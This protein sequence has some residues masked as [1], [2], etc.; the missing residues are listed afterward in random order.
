MH[1]NWLRAGA[2]A[3]FVPAAWGLA[4]AALAAGAVPLR[5][6]D[7][8]PAAYVSP[9]GAQVVVVVAHNYTF[10]I[11]DTIPAG[12]TTLMLH[13]KG[14]ELHEVVLVRLEPGKTIAD[15]LRAAPTEGPDPAWAIAAGG[16]AATLPGG[17]GNATLVLA[18]GH[19]AVLCGVPTAD[20]KP[21]FTLGMMK[22]LT[23]APSSRT[24]PTP[25]S[26]VSVT[27][28]DYSFGISGPL[29]SGPH[30]FR[31]S[32]EAKQG[33]MMLMVRLAPGKTLADWLAWTPKSGTP[34]PIEWTGGMGYMSPGGVGYFSARLSPGTYGLICFIPDAKDH[35][36]HFMHGMQKQFTVS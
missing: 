2:S 25:A 14:T 31:V 11:A 36:P 35:K 26:D 17:E 5:G 13:N 32:N 15:L 34:E 20:G 7:R 33:H 27:M 30:T 9:A 3:G 4:W 28:A 22:D 1:T 19:Y 16:P 8:A 29:S 18:P 23:V 10:Q 24:A 21:H 12:L 6:Q